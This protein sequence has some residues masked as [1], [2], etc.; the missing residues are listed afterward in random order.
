MKLCFCSCRSCRAGRKANRTKIR[1]AI[2]SAKRR[3]KIAIAAGGEPA[4]KV[5]VPYTD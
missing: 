1:R 5:G 3:A 2:R 4:T